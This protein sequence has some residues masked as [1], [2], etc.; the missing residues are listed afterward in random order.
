VSVARAAWETYVIKDRR[1][2]GSTITM[3]L[4]RIRYGIN[5]K[6]IGGKLRQ[7]LKALQLEIHYSKDE[8]LE[9]YLNLA[10]YG[11]NVE[12]AGAASLV[13]FGK[14]ASDLTLEE[15][16]AL[17]VIPQSP[18]RRMPGRSAGETDPLF[19]A[20]NALFEKWLDEHPEDEEQRS[21][22][23]LP[24]VMQGPSELPFLAPH[25]TDDVL[26]ENP[27][28]SELFTTLDLDL[29]QLIER[30]A[31]N[32]VE[33]KKEVG[34]RNVSALIVD[35]RNMGVKAVLGSVD[36]F[37][38]S[39]QGQVNGTRALR[40]PGST[41]KPFIYALGFEQGLIHPMSMLKDSRTS[42][43][44]WSPENFDHKFVGPVKVREAL[45]RSRNLP[46]LEV[47]SMLGEPGLYDFLKSAG[48]EHFRDE[49]FYGLALAMGGAELTMEE[50][51]ELYAMLA[52]G[53]DLRPLNKLKKESE[54]ESEGRRLLSREATYL[55]MDVLKDNPRPYSD[56]P[57]NWTADD[58]AV[59]WKTGTS[60]GFRDAWSVVVFGPYVIAVWVGNFDGEGNPAFVGRQAAGSLFFQ[61]ID[62]IKAKGISPVYNRGLLNVKEVEV[63][64]VSGQLPGRYCD[65]T[66]KTLFIPGKSP[67]RVCDIHREVLV[68]AR[69][70]LRACTE[71]GTQTR[72]EVYEFWP[73]DVLNIFRQAGIPRRTPPPHSPGCSLDVVAEKGLPP[74]ITSPEREVSYTIRA[75]KEGEEKTLPLMAVT[76][77]DSREVYW[78]MDEKFLGKAKSGETFFW[79]PKP[80][81]FVVRVVD[82]H[83]RSDSRGIAVLVVE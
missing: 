36:F 82:D 44:A 2:G 12:G 23:S 1:I 70:G 26:G 61:F 41:I 39:I 62:A 27:R 21:L 40:S 58:I 76:D 11:L 83:G 7:M 64:A 78:F 46:A 81:D 13:Y 20:R 49:S 42:F 56:F 33:R 4:A 66:V 48:I 47:A 77:A 57:I 75:S 29:Q 16:L 38:D 32:Y 59:R 68:D 34:I 74:K 67:I 37:N 15:S 52:N 35:H 55:V 18:G 6:S 5:S 24:V 28:T 60:F 25:F 79:E 72:A 17:S 73:S 45:V 9:A 69:T 80:G 53:G 51:A 3:Q 19:E 31:R 10:P 54:S 22:F 8:I 65:H 50:L 14:R 43:G 30:N 63:C 71:K